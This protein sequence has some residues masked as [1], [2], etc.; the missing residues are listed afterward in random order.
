M[1]L[2]KWLDSINF[3]IEGVLHAART[4][5]HV[6]YHFYAAFIVL[7]GGYLLGVTREEF[8]L[9]ALAVIT[10]L[11]AEL[12]N[13]AMESVVDII[14]PEHS[15]RARQAKDVAAGAVLVTAFGAAVL[16]YVILMPYLMEAFATGLH[17]VHRQ[18]DE[19]AVLA[20]VLVIIVVI[21]LKALIGSGHPLAGGMPS[22]HTAVAFSVFMSVTLSTRNIIAA[23][24]C[25]V[26]AFLIAQS[27]VTA[28]AHKVVEVVAGAV[29][30]AGLTAVLF[31]VFR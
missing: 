1:P 24:L 10:V 15:A 12:M 6:R 30:G 27:R 13:T 17:P 9:L 25:F 16:G 22:G 20:L 28:G 11:L 19:V 31:L 2:R 26:L 21:L 18:G 23:G 5:R 8:V 3:A 14:S 29:L 4:Q 7:T